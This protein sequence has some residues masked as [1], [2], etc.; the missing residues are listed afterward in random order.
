MGSKG[1][2]KEHSKLV[3]QQV[4]RQGGAKSTKVSKPSLSIEVGVHV[5]EMMPGKGY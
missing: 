4:G 3:S 5:E 2:S 1:E